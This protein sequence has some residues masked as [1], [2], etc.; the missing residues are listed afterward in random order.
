MA[1]RFDIEGFAVRADVLSRKWMAAR[2]GM[3]QT[4]LGDLLANLDKF[5]MQQSRYELGSEFIADSLRDDL[6]RHVPGMR[7][8]TF[9][10][11]NAF[12]ERLHSEVANVGV[13]ID[14]LICATSAQLGEYPR[15]F[16]IH[17]DTLTFEPL[18][19]KHSVWLNF[20]KP[21]NLPPD[22][23]SKLFYVENRDRL[24]LFVAGSSEPDDL[25]IYEQTL[26][27]VRNG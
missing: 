26:G 12:C 16:A 8:R 2:L 25:E 11:H 22:R 21:L 27:A 5:G 7:F 9:D 3:K 6:I 18:S 10:D 13:A 1:S 15:R 23:C 19:A 20:R 24:K 14:R 17:F 4:S